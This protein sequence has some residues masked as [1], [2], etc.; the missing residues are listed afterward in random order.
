VKRINVSKLS[1]GFIPD[2]PDLTL[3]AGVW[4]NS[5]NVRYRDNSA[6][7]CRGYSQ[8]LGDLSATAMWAAPIAD[9]TNYYWVYG[10]STVLYA[11]DG[12]THANVSHPSISYNAAE[13]LGWTGGPFHGFMLA[14]D[15]NNIPQ[16]WLPGLGNDFAS[17]TAWP[18]ITCKVLRPFKDFIFALRNTTGGSYNPREVRWSDRAAQGALPQSWDF[19]DPTNQAGIT[20]LGQSEDQLVDAL[21][22]R[23]SLIIYKE[24]HTWAADYVGGRDIFGFRELFAEVGMLAENCACAFKSNHLVLTNDDLVVHDGNSAQSIADKRTRKWL[25]ARINTAR[26]K[27]SFVVPDYRNREVYIYFPEPGNDWPNL[28]LV[29]NWAEDNFH[30][31]D[32]GGPKSWAVPGIAPGSAISFDADSPGTFDEASGLFDEETYSPF[33]RRVM[34]FD[35]LAQRA[36]QNDTGETYNGQAMTVFAERSGIGV[37]EDLGSIK[38]V[39]RLW[40]RLEGT[41]GDILNFWIGVK[42]TIQSPTTWSGPYPFT[43]GTDNWIDTR[44]DGRIFDIRHEYLGSNTYRLFGISFDFAFTGLR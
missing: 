31:F 16:S 42:D 1:G 13:D 25:F 34:I 41:V 6:E 7:K 33:S 17:L 22:L 27:R 5:R 39:W 11:T 3:P 36:Y 18:A 32:L 23:D 14:N 15:A 8:A 30:V 43:I 44:L 21:G 10:S 26:Y 4:T 24:S 20:E 37:T 40:P 38:R 28:A 9:G 12:T 29:W 19:A 35:S 2:Q